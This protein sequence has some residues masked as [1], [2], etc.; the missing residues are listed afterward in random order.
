MSRNIIIY[1]F[2]GTLTPYKLPK[3]E[4]LEK[5]GLEGGATNPEFFKMVNEKVQT[6]GIDLYVALYE[7][8]F[9]IIKDANLKLTYS[10][11]C[12]GSDRVIY[13]K[14]VLG[15]LE[16]LN[17]YNIRN[18]LLSTGLKIYLENTSVSKYFLEI[19][20]T[21]F[22]Y[23]SNNEVSN[24]KYLMSDKNKVDAI[25]DIIKNNGNMDDDCSN[26]IYIGDGFSD[27]YAMK[28]VKDNGGT[29]IFVHNG[30]DKQDLM[31]L[32]DM[33]VISFSALADFSSN[34]KLTNYVKKLCNIRDN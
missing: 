3:F 30:K 18:Y 32:E 23:D 25:K 13:N 22:N 24:I 17:S 6:E 10:N 9:N 11:L 28:Y 20:A 12:L 2:D 29:S 1:D 15:F 5:C 21:T 8:Y 14:G 33:D 31:R 19:Y 4:I 27:Y 16:F 34:S 26:V 7:I